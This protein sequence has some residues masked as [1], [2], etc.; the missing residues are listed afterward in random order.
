MGEQIDHIVWHEGQQRL[1]VGYVDRESD[2]IVADRLVATK[3]AEDAGLFL[4][5]APPGM[6]VWVRR[7]RYWLQ[8]DSTVDPGIAR[9]G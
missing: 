9:P 4:V 1:E 5:P 7:A 8:G 3:L 2:L 6:V